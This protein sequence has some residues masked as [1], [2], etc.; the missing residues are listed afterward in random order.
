MIG[1]GMHPFADFHNHH[2]RFGNLNSPSS[3]HDP[4]RQQMALFDNFFSPM[5]MSVFNHDPFGNDLHGHNIG[6]ISSFN[7]SV[8]LVFCFIY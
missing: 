1:F 6:S 2:H 3:R 5:R 7:F 4:H 8:G